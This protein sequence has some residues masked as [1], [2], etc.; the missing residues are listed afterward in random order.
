MN[1]NLKTAL[2]ILA[3]II[4]AGAS[5]AYGALTAPKG[6]QNAIKPQPTKQVVLTEKQLEEKLL[7][8]LPAITTVLIAKYPLVAT[9]Y[10]VDQGKLYEQGKWYGTT[11]T[12][13]GKDVDNR[14][15][16]R[17]LMQ[18]K[19]G[20]WVLR[21]TPPRPLL[22]AKDFTDVPVKIIKAI[23]KPVSLPGTDSS[24]TLSVNE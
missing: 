13:K 24:P 2:V 19:D 15:T 11:L 10:N 5:L 18:K 8:E 1:K 16:L 23:N 9:D 6:N 7:T 17:V 3:A 14:D 12:Y 20:Q 21:T 22:Y 4:I